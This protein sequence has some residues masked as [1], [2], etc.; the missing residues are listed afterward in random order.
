[1]DGRSDQIETG[2]LTAVQVK[3]LL[4]LAFHV[5]LHIRPSSFRH[6][7]YIYCGIKS[8]SDKKSDDQQKLYY[9]LMRYEDVDV[10][11]LR[12]FECFLEAAP[13]LA[14]QIYI[15]VLEKPDEDIVFG[16]ASRVF[17]CSIIEN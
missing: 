13:Q 16:N 5:F 12:L 8:K 6:I 1:M 7:E 14:L 11:M 10:C 9:K 15:W 3:S 17:L 4:S 2:V